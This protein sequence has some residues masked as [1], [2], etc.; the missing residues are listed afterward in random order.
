LIFISVEMAEM[1]E[2]CVA[3][4]GLIAENGGRKTQKETE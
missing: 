4:G 3:E 2:L 1:I